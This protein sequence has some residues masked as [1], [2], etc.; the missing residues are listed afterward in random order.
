MP[1]ECCSPL[2]TAAQRS[3][4]HYGCVLHSTLRPRLQRLR[5]TTQQHFYW[6]LAMKTI[7]IVT[8][9]ATALSLTGAGCASRSEDVAAAYVSPMAYSSYSCREL[10]AEA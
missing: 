7:K 4:S 9:L 6:S 2:S 3:K 1:G 10:G 5:N 8:A